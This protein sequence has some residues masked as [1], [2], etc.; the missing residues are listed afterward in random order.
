[1]HVCMSCVALANSAACLLTQRVTM[2]TVLQ[3]GVNN[4]GICMR[5]NV[6][7]PAAEPCE[8]VTRSTAPL[9][10]CSRTC[11]LLIAPNLCLLFVPQFQATP[12]SITIMSTGF[13]QIFLMFMP[14]AIVHVRGLDSHPALGIV[15]YFFAAVLL[16][17]V[18]EVANQLERPWAYIPLDDIVAGTVRDIDR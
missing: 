7:A 8:H 12:Y 1:M 17:G 11:M 5:I 2:E 3:S 6:S 9:H 14:V 16:L 10:A 18:D 13:L 15:I 4:M